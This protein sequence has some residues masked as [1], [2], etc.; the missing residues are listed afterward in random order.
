MTRVLFVLATVAALALSGCI[1]PLV[2]DDVPPGDL[3]LPAGADVPLASGALAAQIAANDGVDAFIP[4]RSA[5]SGGAQIHYWDL[6][7]TTRVAAPIWVIVKEDPDG[8]FVAGDKTYAPVGQG[9]IVDAVPGDPGYG[10]FWLFSVVPVTERWDGELFTSVAAVE[11]GV[12]SGLLE[13]PIPVGRAFNCPIVAS[14]TRLDRGPGLEPRAPDPGYYRG[15]IV[16]YFAFG[17]APVDNLGEVA[18]APVYQLRR[19]GGEPL[20]EVYRGVDMTGDGDHLDSNDL[21]AASLGDDGY[22]G[23]VRGVEVVVRSDYRS[24]D[25]SGDDADADLTDAAQLFTAADEPDPSWVVAVYPQ[26]EVRN[27]PVQR[28]PEASP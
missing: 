23:L 15:V 20:D 2:S 11:V 22:T 21:F 12:A 27:R 17:G 24:I 26:D 10:P 1:D 25:T 9:N 4:L 3:V 7:P 6:G 8:N 5:F 14:G 28:P 19:E 18:T 13:P 16:T